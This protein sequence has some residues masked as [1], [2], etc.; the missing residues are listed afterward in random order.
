MRSTG[1]KIVIVGLLLSVMQ[2]CTTTSKA[3]L[4]GLI[5]KPIS[6]A[7]MA[8]GKAPNNSM[9]LEDGTRVYTWRWPLSGT[10]P[11]STGYLMYEV[12]TLW[13]NSSGKIIRYQRQAE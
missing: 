2:A 11:S 13:G 10:G 3:Q 1:L 7:S 5:G 9:Q 6:E 12:V 8:F 4:D